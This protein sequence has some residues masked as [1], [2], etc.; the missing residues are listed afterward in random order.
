LPLSQVIWLAVI[1]GL[2]EF[3][4]ISSTAHLVIVPRLLH[5]RDPGL[6]FD[7]ALHFGTLIAVVVYFFPTWITLVRAALG[8][9]VPI[10][11]DEPEKGTLTPLESRH[12][13]LLLAYLAVA[14][15]PAMI[16][17]LLLHSAAEGALRTPAVIGSA[18]II[19]GLYMWWSERS[20]RCER[21]LLGTGFGDAFSIGLA[22]A[23]AVISGVSRS[24]STISTGLLRN[25]KREASTRFSFLLSTPIIAGAASRGTR[26]TDGWTTSRNALPVFSWS[27]RIGGG[28]LHSDL[29]TD[30]LSSNPI[31]ARVRGVLDR[32]GHF[33][34]CRW[35]YEASLAVSLR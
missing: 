28:R 20:G 30:P 34:S 23:F 4:P 7:I 1:Q 17:G 21:S 19:V 10:S 35:H 9:D 29:G 13:R 31:P 25:M 26:A 24:G 5:W 12:E 11:R 2:T 32:G 3:L 22:Q 14:T 15:I 16:S 6:G 27:T 33:H 8:A 18:M